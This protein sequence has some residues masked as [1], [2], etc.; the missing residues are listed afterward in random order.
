MIFFLPT[1]IDVDAFVST[2]GPKYQIVEQISPL[3]MPCVQC[4]C[5]ISQDYKDTRPCEA[6]KQACNSMCK[7]SMFILNVLRLSFAAVC[8][9]AKPPTL[10]LIILNF[11]AF[12]ITSVHTHF[13][14]SE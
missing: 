3:K 11:V 1:G 8:L 4:S 9:L 2:Q 14:K 12:V 6:Y 13:H 10:L 7:I 5:L